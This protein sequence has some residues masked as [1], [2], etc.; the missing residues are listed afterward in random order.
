MCGCLIVC[1]H[2]WMDALRKTVSTAA[3]LTSSFVEAETITKIFGHEEDLITFED[4]GSWFG[5]CSLHWQKL[6]QLPHVSRVAC[7]SLLGRSSRYAP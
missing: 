1:M 6:L 4:T 3:T 7:G 2:G 5:P